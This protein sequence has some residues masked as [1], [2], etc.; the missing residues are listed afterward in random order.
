MNKQTNKNTHYKKEYEQ[1]IINELHL[2]IGEM[3]DSLKTI[4]DADEYATKLGTI[5]KVYKYLK[6]FDEVE[7]EIDKVIKRIEMEKKF[8]FCNRER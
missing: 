3:L 5:F 6:Y 1:E 4:E 2:K 7:P 8:N